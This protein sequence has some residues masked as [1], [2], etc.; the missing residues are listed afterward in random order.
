[1]KESILHSFIMIAI[2]SVVLNIAV[3]LFVDPI[4]HFLKV[5]ES[6][7]AMMR[8]YLWI[9]FYGITATF[10]Y[11]FFASLLRAIGNSVTPLIFLGVCAVLNIIL[12]LLFVIQFKW[13][14]AGAAAATV[15]AQYVSGLGL[16]AYSIL[17]RSIPSPICQYRILVMLFLLSLLKILVPRKQ[18]AFVP[19]SKVQSIVP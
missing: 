11:N 12:D 19:E 4:L 6:I 3:F 16:F 13:G 7:Y 5:P 14:V 15:I 9:I 18:N 8:S 10:F 2:L 1:M 17:Y